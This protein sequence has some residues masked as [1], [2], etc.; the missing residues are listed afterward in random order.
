MSK[1]PTEE[2]E[3]VEGPLRVRLGGGGGGG[4]DLPAGGDVPAPDVVSD[5][6]VNPEDGIS[7][8]RITLRLV[9]YVCVC[10][11]V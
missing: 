8:D 2:D 4:G 5:S 9:L 3:E 11:R 6:G 10:V 1:Y 7:F